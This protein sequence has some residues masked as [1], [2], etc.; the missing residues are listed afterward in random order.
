MRILWSEQKSPCE[1]PGDTNKLMF[2]M[3][4]GK[5]VFH[6]FVYSHSVFIFDVTCCSVRFLKA[7]FFLFESGL[8][9][10]FESGLTCIKLLLLGLVLHVGL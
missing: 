5:L 8:C 6:S 9:E 4:F 3:T 10:V 2:A 1:V 7:N